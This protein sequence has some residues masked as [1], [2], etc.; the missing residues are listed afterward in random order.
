MCRPDWEKCADFV[1]GGITRWQELSDGK[2]SNELVDVL[3]HEIS[4][5][6]FVESAGADYFEGQVG[7]SLHKLNPLKLKE[8][9]NVWA[10]VCTHLWEL[11]EV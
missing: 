7:P 9:D 5:G 4:A 1:Q 3:L 2:A 8:I 11:R 10:F 6:G